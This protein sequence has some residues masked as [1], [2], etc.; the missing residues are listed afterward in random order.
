MLIKKLSY[1]HGTLYCNTKPNVYIHMTC[2]NASACSMTY[3]MLYNW[4]FITAVKF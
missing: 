4:M 3:Y 2:A 1:Q